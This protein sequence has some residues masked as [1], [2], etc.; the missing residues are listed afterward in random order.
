[1]GSEHPVDLRYYGLRSL[2]AVEAAQAYSALG[3]VYE[4][5]VVL[6]ETMVA[7]GRR[8][9]LLQRLVRNPGVF[10]AALY[11]TYGPDEYPGWVSE[12][13]RDIEELE[14]VDQQR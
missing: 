1:M 2:L 8:N 13:R 6:W 5:E 4:P 11:N 9:R 12:L 10:I 7:A 14:T 3:G